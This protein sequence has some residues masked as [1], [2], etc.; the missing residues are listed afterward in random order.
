MEEFCAYY[1]ST[2]IARRGGGDALFKPLLWNQFETIKSGGAETN[3]QLEAY[4]KK[5]NSLAGQKTNVWDI[6]KLVKMQEADTRRGFLANAVGQDLHAN[7]GRRM[8]SLDSKGRIKFL[9]DHFDTT[10]NKEYILMLAHDL[11]KAG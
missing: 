7:T 9:V 6:L 10:P 3:N 8:S 11:Q 2:W 4:N 1:K 5:F